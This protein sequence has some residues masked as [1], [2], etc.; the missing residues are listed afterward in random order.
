MI[1][2]SVNRFL[3]LFSSSVFYYITG[4]LTFL[5]VRLLGEGQLHF[6]NHFN[7][8]LPLCTVFTIAAHGASS[9]P[10]TSNVS[11]TSV[12]IAD[13]YHK[14]TS[15]VV[16]ADVSDVYSISNI[17]QA[18]GVDSVMKDMPTPDNDFNPTDNTILHQQTE[19]HHLAHR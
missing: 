3:M 9:S 15:F 11:S 5:M 14:D 13:I 2:S 18:V 8:T 12:A 7:V 17:K 16:K 10:M 19:R 6:S 4:K 1:C